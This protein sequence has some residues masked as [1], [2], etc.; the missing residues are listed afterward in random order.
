MRDTGKCK[1][2]DES[3]IPREW[4]GGPCYFPSL[5]VCVYKFSSYYLNNIRFTD[6]S[7]GPLATESAS[8]WKLLHMFRVI[9]SP[10]IRSANNCIY[11]IWYLSHRYCYQSLS[12]KSWN[13]FECA[14]VGI[15]YPQHTQT[16]SN[17]ST[18]AV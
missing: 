11:G 5:P 4:G 12:W 2:L 10:I 15:R 18:I 8:I 16:G 9:P 17:S 14:V 1:S 6:N 7:L 3:N 13:R